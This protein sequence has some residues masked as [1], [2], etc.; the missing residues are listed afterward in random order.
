MEK[1]VPRNSCY[2]VICSE[3]RYSPSGFSAGKQTDIGF[4]G[5]QRGNYRHG[6]RV[7]KLFFN[8]NSFNNDGKS[9]VSP[10]YYACDHRSHS[11]VNNNGRTVELHDYLIEQLLKTARFLIEL[12]FNGT[13]STVR[14][15]RA[16]KI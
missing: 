4:H 15:Y 2:A 16:L 13:F 3:N 12:G 1:L 14:L 9:Q 7:Q 8:T 11:V 6:R 5:R 10:E